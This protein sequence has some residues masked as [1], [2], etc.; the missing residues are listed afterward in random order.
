MIGL[1]TGRCGTTSL[2]RLLKSATGCHVAHEMDRIRTHMTWDFTKDG[3]ERAIALIESMPGV[4]VGD[5]GFY[6]LPYVEGISDARPDVTFICMKR[7]RQETI[8]SYMKKTEGRDHWRPGMGRPDPWDRMYPKFDRPTKREAIGAYWDMYYQRSAALEAAGLRIK[9]F[10]ISSLNDER[11]V[12]SI[13]EFA[14]LR[15]SG[16]AVGIRENAKRV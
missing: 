14:G 10:D 15:P 12:K 2:A 3:M 5:V 11:G 13:M 9:T 8:E 1:G 16:A 6:Y 4:M 7:D